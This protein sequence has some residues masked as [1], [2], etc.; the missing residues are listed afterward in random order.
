MYRRNKNQGGRDMKFYDDT[1]YYHF[2]T[3]PTTDAE[4]RQILMEERMEYA[5]EFMGKAFGPEKTVSD[6]I[7]KYIVIGGFVLAVVLLVIF[8]LNKMVPGIIYTVAGLFIFFGIL[9][10][11]P[12]NKNDQNMDLPG[13][14]KLPRPVFCSLMFILGIAVLIPAVL[15]PTQ[16]YAKATVGGIATFF[17][18]IGLFFIGYTIYGMARRAKAMKEKVSAKCIGYIKMVGSS[19]NEHGGSHLVVTGTPVFEYHYNG[20]KFQAF[21]ES[22]IKTG[23]LSPAVGEIVEVGVIPEDPYDVFYRKTTAAN[24]FAIVLA[25][26]AIGAGV[27]MFIMLPNVSDKNGFSVNSMGGEVQLAKA[28]FDDALIES[29]VNTSDFTIEYVTVTSVYQVGEQW[30][31]DLSNDTKRGIIEEDKDKYYEGCGIYLVIPGEGSQGLS[32]IADEWEY[33][34]SHEVIN[35][36]E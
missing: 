16:G 27:F 14:A 21:Q 29:Y 35:K 10:L 32:F 15:A 20:R 17:V 23:A 12:S 30:A 33:T 36:P 34:G 28:Q 9:S 2:S 5:K 22:A 31:M 24:I 4:E 25:L 11:L 7:K 1:K 6:N 19:N 8:S 3:E 13:Q 18:I 26:L